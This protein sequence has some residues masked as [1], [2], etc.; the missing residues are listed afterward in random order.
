MFIVFL[1]LVVLFCF[2]LRNNTIMLIYCM[3]LATRKWL[4]PVLAIWPVF[5]CHIVMT[6]FYDSMLAD[7]FIK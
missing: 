6:Y 5:S 7:K 3:P 2:Y 1:Y 4:Y